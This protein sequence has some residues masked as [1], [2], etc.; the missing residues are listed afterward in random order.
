MNLL[1]LFKH[2]R[3]IKEYMAGETIRCGKRKND[4]HQYGRAKAL[5]AGG[6][7]GGN[8][9]LSR[10][11]GG[12]HGRIGEIFAKDHSAELASWCPTDYLLGGFKTARK[13]LEQP[14]DCGCGHYCPHELCRQ[15]GQQASNR[16]IVP[17]P[18]GKRQR[19][20]RV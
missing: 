20:G 16:E 4:E 6:M 8:K 9:H 10:R 3:T 14:G 7:A 17:P 5:D 2:A 18:E 19:Y 13:R 12:E 11:I 1:G 15:I